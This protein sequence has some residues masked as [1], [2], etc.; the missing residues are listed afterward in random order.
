MKKIQLII[1]LFF[2]LLISSCEKQDS[3]IPYWLSDYKELYEEDPI[4]AS[5]QWFKDAKMGLFVHFTIGSL[6]EEGS[7]DYR[8]WADGNADERICNYVGI[9]MEDYQNAQSKDS[10]LFSKFEIPEFD[11]E[12]ICQLAVKANMKYITFTAHHQ[13]CNFD[14]EHVPFNSV[15]SSPDGRDLVAEMMAACKK[16]KLAPFFYMG[17]SYKKVSTSN[18]EKNLA[19][20]NELLTEYGPIGGLWFDGGV[21]SDPENYEGIDEINYFIKDLQPHCLVSFKLGLYGCSEDYISPEFFMLPFEYEM[22]TEGQ[23]L[24]LD[25]RMRRWEKDEKEGWEKCTK[26][27]L[28][29]ICTSMMGSKWRDWDTE[30]LGWVNEVGARRLSGEEAYYWLTYSRYTGSNMLMNIGPRA[31]GSVHPDTE[32]GLIELGQIIQERGWPEIVHEIPDRP[33]N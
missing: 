15:N 30:N 8:K 33:E 29:E 13:S 10:L 9:S 27:K 4:E 5:R 31:D 12:K 7:W 14:A 24:R 25:S 28:R 32:K 6:M 20:L 23:Q 21:A 1:F 18:K 19:T 17:A 3:E 16:Y 26:Y 11:A 22:Q 2:A